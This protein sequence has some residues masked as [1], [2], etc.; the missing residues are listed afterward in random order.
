MRHIDNGVS[1]DSC[2][3]SSDIH[4][5]D[6]SGS[7]SSD[8][9]V[10]TN[11]SEPTSNPFLYLPVKFQGIEVHSLL[12]T[13][14]S[15]NVIS[16]TLFN[17][18]PH[19]CR[20]EI[21]QTA[22]HI[23]QLA[24][25]KNVSVIGTS[26]VRASIPQGPC[27]FQVYI[28]PHTSNPLILGTE[29]MH[30]HKFVLDFAKNC[31]FSEPKTRKLKI[32]CNA[33]ITVAPNSEC[34]IQGKLPKG[35]AIG[36]QGICTSSKFA[37]KSGLLV[38]RSVV[39]VH[40]S[41]FIPLKILNPGNDHISFHKGAIIAN[42][43]PLSDLHEI[44]HNATSVAGGCNS[45]NLANESTSHK[46]DDN[47][48][49]KS[50]NTGTCCTNLNNKESGS[51]DVFTNCDEGSCCF[52][53]FISHFDLDIEH[54]SS[55]E[56]DELKHC[57]YSNRDIFVTKQ[58]PS[59]GFT[60]VVEHKIHLKKDA[61]PKHH[62][63]YRL[64]PD[65]KEV[66][67]TQL[68]ELLKQG[69]IEPVSESE[70]IPISSP[71]VL[72][73]KRKKPDNKNNRAG[74]KDPNLASYRFC[75]DFR[76][77]NSQ[78]EPFRYTI[79][80]L[81][82]LT[83][84]FDA[85]GPKFIT[86][87]DMCSGFFQMGIDKSS[88]KYTAFNTCFGT[89]KFLRLPMGLSTAPNSFQLLMDKVLRGLT[90]RSV[91]CYLDDI[92]ICSSTFPQHLSDLGE[93]FTRL[94]N[95]GLKLG[96][97]KCVFARDK[98]VFLGHEISR[99]GIKPPSDRV[100]AL[101]HYPT[102]QNQQQLRRAMGLLNWFR[103]FVPNFSAIACPLNELLKNGVKFI[104]TT[105]HQSAFDK[106]KDLLV[107]SEALAFPRYDLEFRLAVD[108][109]CKGVGY[110]LY[111]IHENNEVRVV[112]FGSKGLN[113][114]QQSYGPTKLELL[115][116][117]FSVLDCAPY[118]R[119]RH[120]VVECDH[121][122]LQPLF[123]K[124][125]RGAIYERWIAI[126]QQFDISIEWK[127]GK[128]MVVPDA[129][130]RC[131][132]RGLNGTFDSSPAEEDHYFPYV[133]DPHSTGVKLPTGQTLSSLVG[134]DP[135]DSENNNIN[136]ENS[137]PDQ[138]N[139]V[140]TLNPNEPRELNSI[141]HTVPKMITT[142]VSDMFPSND[143]SDIDIAYDADTELDMCSDK[144][145]QKRKHFCN[146]LNSK[147]RHPPVHVTN[148]DVHVSDNDQLSDD[149]LY[150]ATTDIDLSSSACYRQHTDIETES[151]RDDSLIDTE[152][153]KAEELKAGNNSLFSTTDMSVD[154]IAQLQRQDDFSKP[155]IAYLLSGDLP[156]SQKDARRLILESSDFVL[157]DNVLFHSRVQKSKR[158]KH[159][160][161]YQLV[162]PQTLIHTVLNLCHDCPISGH[163]GIQETLDRVREH[164]YFPKYSVL[165]TD[166]VRSCTSCQQRKLGPHVKNPIT[167]FP[168]PSR[169]F[170][171]WELDLYG[172]LP[173][174]ASGKQYIFTAVDM[175][176]KYLF[177]MPISN[178]DALTVGIAIFQLISTFGVCETFV[179]DQGSEFI[180]KATKETCKLLR[181]HMDFIPSYAHHCLGACERTHRVLGTKLTPYMNNHRNN[182]EEILPA[183]V[184]SINTSVN[185]TNGYSPFEIVFGQRPCFPLG[186]PVINLEDVPKDISIYVSKL[187]E[188]LDFVRSHML[189]NVSNSKSEMTERKN[190]KSSILKISVGDYVYLLHEPSGTGQKLQTIYR[191]PYVVQ[192]I[193]SPH[194]LRIRDSS[195]NKIY[196]PVHI[197]RVKI[198]HVRSPTPGNY[199]HVT[200][201]V[202]VDTAVQ[203]EADSVHLDSPTVLNAQSPSLTSEEIT[204]SDMLHI[205]SEKPLVTRSRRRIRKPKR[206][207]NEE[208]VD[209]SA[210]SSSNTDRFY[211]VKRVL[212]QRSRGKEIEYLV[213]F[214]G[215]PAQ[216][217]E[218]VTFRN[219]NT[220]TQ[221]AVRLNPPKCIPG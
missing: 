208:H 187:Q 10:H 159:M 133:E 179:S 47:D 137:S 93:V 212:G 51:T 121:R 167:A 18:L 34:I 13:G 139:I 100:D 160:C 158:T 165:V 36:I 132:P 128:Q 135:V 9:Y 89:Y 73:S 130:S 96:P 87:I 221:R 191:G 39:T 3:E 109:S 140:P 170:Q 151:K 206:Y 217:A 126:L 58:N 43:E 192:E 153:G 8:S 117:V 173:V 15:I 11:I 81:Q 198:A 164:Y 12:D 163:C 134:P 79:P 84:S 123:Q 174:T 119:G 147:K 200:S 189:A 92:L 23:V 59:L 172:P 210:L 70:N 62:Q 64:S 205:S 110:M 72:V 203:T 102:P 186:N 169:A 136:S 53:E 209:P 115:G 76:Y 194:L 127:P 33:P 26:I 98:C 50:N 5:N 63:P 118:V 111:Q 152:T 78:T 42:L 2:S 103:K 44:H 7:V 69:I 171:V 193:I 67:R 145:R 77:L 114:Y 104:W 32:R 106:L 71:I 94:R 52:D 148:T 181:I 214:A 65:K 156:V 199:F 29:F 20:S 180:A 129:L 202:K 101:K 17:S 218:W 184:F 66:L 112:R 113:R 74:T 90:F 40:N 188:K 183:I 166:Y 107:N 37:V 28:L 4:S 185:S 31:Y 48:I 57:L 14:C 80:N 155:I 60:T 83:E 38:A 22:G 161:H 91:L 168:T 125:L 35:T 195:T 178:D 86:S 216:N 82:E 149:L 68:D 146:V 124:Q 213:H 6:C 197:N 162:V 95:A 143:I 1:T 46:S 154:H 105:I 131:Y 21:D 55:V 220:T 150:N 54:L 141:K 19:S 25:S 207:R 49:S 219:L 176:S 204:S 142:G 138:V 24:D 16:E 122:A 215:E 27:S 75:C 201:T 120:F 61:V 211:K 157:I 196:K 45:V 108:T 144:S 175:F 97:E 30:R 85:Q 116:M 41:R 182:W 56:L 88:S 99:E 190:E 177:T